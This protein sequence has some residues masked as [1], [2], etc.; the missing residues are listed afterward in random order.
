MLNEEDSFILDDEE[1]V[2]A[3]YVVGDQMKT[4]ITNSLI[5]Y[6]VE[7]ENGEERNSF[8]S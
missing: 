3:C 6:I 1:S 5:G 4:D 7:V 8:P 2:T